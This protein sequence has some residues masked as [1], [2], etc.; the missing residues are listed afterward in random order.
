MNEFPIHTEQRRPNALGTVSAEAGTGIYE[1][2]AQ[3]PLGILG[4]AR[5]G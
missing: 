3:P 1:T 5:K 4:H 2:E